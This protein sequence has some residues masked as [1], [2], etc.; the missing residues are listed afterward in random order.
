MQNYVIISFIMDLAIWIILKNIFKESVPSF[1][2]LLD[3]RFVFILLIYVVIINSSLLF[4]WRLF[5]RYFS[6]FL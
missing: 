3:F 6:N 1:D 4:F 2:D 5:S